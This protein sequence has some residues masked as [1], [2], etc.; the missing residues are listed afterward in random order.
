VRDDVGVLHMLGMDEQRLAVALRLLVDVLGHADRHQLAV[1]AL[2]DELE[3]VAAQH[4]TVDVDDV[5]VDDAPDGRAQRAAFGQGAL[6]ATSSEANRLTQ[7]RQGAALPQ[8]V[9]T[10]QGVGVTAKTHER[11]AVDDVVPPARLYWFASQ[12]LPTL[13]AAE[14]SGLA[15]E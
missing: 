10:A 8:P 3:V 14:G 5:P 13:P 7:A 1:P 4:P 11:Q 15:P 6:P 9:A 12:T 2:A